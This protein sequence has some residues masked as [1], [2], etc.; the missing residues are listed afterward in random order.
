MSSLSHFTPGQVAPNDWQGG[1]DI[2]YKLGPGFTDNNLKVRLEVNNDYVTKPIY[3]VIGTVFG[4]DEPDRMVLMGSHR[5]AWVFGGVDPSSSSSVM[6]EV[7]RGIGELLTK[8]DWR[9]RRTIMLCSW[10]AEEFGLIGSFEWVEDNRNILRNRAVVYIDLNSVVSGNYSFLARG[11]PLLTELVYGKSRAVK[12]PN[13]PDGD[14]TLYDTWS[15]NYPAPF[16]PDKPDFGRMLFASDYVPLSKFVGV[17]SLDVAY[18][19]QSKMRTSNPVSHT[20]YDTFYWQ[21]TFNDP[22]FKIHLA[23]AQISA[24]I[25]VGVADEHVLPYNLMHYKS[26]LQVNV[27]LLEKQYTSALI[28]GNVT[29]MY[30]KEAVKTFSQSAEDFEARKAEVGSDADFATLR[31]LNDKMILMERSFIWPYGMPG[32]LWYRHVIFENR[33]HYGV[34]SFPGISEVLSTIEETKDW[35]EVKR[36]VSIVTQCL[37]EAARVLA[38]LEKK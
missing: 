36:Q 16:E 23:I 6:M 19:F 17:P 35:D 22:N 2:T 12:D 34:P 38:P 21:K 11:S 9:P 14:D 13:D 29:L 37:R 28:E 26:T 30:L 4:K 5:D 15:K 32:R 20:M 25:L 18:T 10:G 7:S 27:D 33:F 31:M 1:L 24:R 3:N 8:T